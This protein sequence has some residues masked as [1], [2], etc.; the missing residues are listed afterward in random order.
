MSNKNNNNGY[1][2]NNA[3]NSGNG[4]YPASGYY[5]ANNI[6]HYQSSAHSPAPYTVANNPNV[7]AGHGE[8]PGYYAGNS[9]IRNA[10]PS[11]TYHRTSQQA[12]PAAATARADS[13]AH[14]PP[15]GHSMPPANRPP[16]YY[17]YAPG[18]P[19]QQSPQQHTG[20]SY[21]PPTNRAA[22]SGA[23]AQGTLNDLNVVLPSFEMLMRGVS[24]RPTGSGSASD[25]QA[26]PQQ[27]PAYAESLARAPSS[28]LPLTS[29]STPTTSSHNQPQSGK[30]AGELGYWP[31]NLP[32]R[33]LNRIVAS[34]S[35]VSAESLAQV[36]PPAV[37]LSTGPKLP[38]PSSQNQLQGGNAAQ[39]VRSQS[40]HSVQPVG[41]G[42]HRP[43]PVQ[44]DGSGV[45]K[46]KSHNPSPKPAPPTR[47]WYPIPARDP[48]MEQWGGQVKECRNRKCLTKG[49][50]GIDV[51]PLRE[52][53]HNHSTSFGCKPCMVSAY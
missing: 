52:G 31:Q 5:T 33:G 8:N 4:N 39:G 49:L 18:H 21:A 15:T 20:G 17:P 26:T 7:G 23:P 46:T 2:P 40:F 3:Y 48:R 42:L 30:I 37:P 53:S 41:N 12:T 24:P 35:T 16:G 13:I 6:S 51:F 14:Y 28:G 29:A 10:G 44:S 1:N 19:G 34:Q 47:P 11:M 43:Q 22:H 32:A 45:E 25:Y 38:P 27:S 50:V 36:A 9:S